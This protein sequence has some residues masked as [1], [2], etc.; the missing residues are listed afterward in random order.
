[1]AKCH[2]ASRLCLV[3]GLKLKTKPNLP[4]K[5]QL[6][7][8]TQPQT[9]PNSN[10]FFCA[11]M[12]VKAPWKRPIW[13]V[14]HTQGLLKLYNSFEWKNGPEAVDHIALIITTNALGLPGAF[15]NCFE[16][17]RFNSWV[18]HSIHSNWMQR[19]NVDYQL[20]FQSVSH[21]VFCMP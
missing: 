20:K 21:S 9:V 5:A 8:F 6:K 15:M 16:L 2:K 7:S 10:D 14:H 1:M 18:Q 3:F 19:L 11:Y 13:F 4:E 12:H 17:C